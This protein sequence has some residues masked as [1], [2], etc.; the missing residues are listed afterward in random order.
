MHLQINFFLRD[1]LGLVLSSFFYAFQCLF[2]RI[3]WVLH[4]NISECSVF[5]CI[6]YFGKATH[7]SAAHNTSRC[8]AQYFFLSRSDFITSSVIG[9]TSPQI[10][11]R[12]RD[13]WQLLIRNN[14]II[15]HTTSALI[16]FFLLFNGLYIFRGHLHAERKR[17]QERRRAAAV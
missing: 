6:N 13:Q 1:Y 11:T 15:F 14:Q 9:C 7:K 8:T 3:V 4:L 17:E 12:R 10:W 16:S 2:C 5:V